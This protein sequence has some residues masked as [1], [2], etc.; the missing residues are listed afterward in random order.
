MVTVHLYFWGWHYLDFKYP[1]ELMEQISIHNFK[2][3]IHLL[4]EPD[5]FIFLWLAASPASTQ[6]GSAADNIHRP[7]WSASGHGADI[8]RGT[9][10]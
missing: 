3:Q 7:R 4:Q 1:D 2:P 9:R 5:S 10:T 6:R 8:P